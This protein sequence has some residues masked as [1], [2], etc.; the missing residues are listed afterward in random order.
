HVVGA[1]ENGDALAREV[2]DHLPELAARVRI[3]TR[4]RLVE[5]QQLRLVRHAGGE[6]QP[7]LPAAGERAGQLV[8]A[9][10][11]A[12][13]LDD[14]LGARRQRPDAVHAADEFEVLAHR[15]VL[16]EAEALRHVADAPLDLG[17][18]RAD[19][20]AEALARAG[21]RREQAAEHADRRR[22]A[23]AVGPE[24]AEDHAARHLDGEVLHH[25]LVAE[26]LGEAADADGRLRVVHGP[27]SATST[28]WP[29]RSASGCSV[30]RASI[31]NTRRARS[32]RLWVDGGGYS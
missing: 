3:D 16:V 2:V 10:L 14:R 24:E 28:G 25:G 27:V 32:L 4:G 18:L 7:L 22:L 6:R 17:G 5:Q 11:E 12:E 1:D 26:A 30:G 29:T 21:I 23:A 9:A 13:A 20:E 15:Q 19:V 8:L 31:M